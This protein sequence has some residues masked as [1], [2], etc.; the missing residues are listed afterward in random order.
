M[1]A[2]SNCCFFQPLAVQRALSQAG[3]TMSDIDGIAFT[4]GPGK[5]FLNTSHPTCVV[6]VTIV[7]GMPGCLSVAAGTAK[8]IAAA[9]GKPLVGVHHMVRIRNEDGE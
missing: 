6:Q 4:R 5:P 1:Y 7:S 8:G 3:C 2:Y 9:L